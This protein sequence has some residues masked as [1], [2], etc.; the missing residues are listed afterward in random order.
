MDLL[1]YGIRFLYS[2]FIYSE[3]RSFFITHETTLL[4]CWLKGRTQCTELPLY[5]GSGAVMLVMLH[6]F[7]ICNSNAH[8][9]FI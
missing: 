3:V 6:N 4:L 8:F 5:A 1:E 9:T 2:F 7:F